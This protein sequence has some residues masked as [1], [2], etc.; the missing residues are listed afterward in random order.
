MSRLPSD[1]SGAR[2]RDGGVEEGPQDGWKRYQLPQPPE[3]SDRALPD[4]GQ[5]RIRRV[6][7]TVAL[8]YLERVANAIGRDTRA[9]DVVRYPELDSPERTAM[10]PLVLDEVK[11]F[12]EMAARAHAL[13]VDGT[14]YAFPS[15]RMSVHIERA[16]AGDLWDTTWLV[17]DG[18]QN[19]RR[20]QAVEVL[21]RS[22]EAVNQAGSNVIVLNRT[23]VMAFRTCSSKPFH[24][25]IKDLVSRGKCTLNE[26]IFRSLS[27]SGAA[28]YWKMPAAREPNEDEDDENDPFDTRFTLH[29]MQTVNFGQ[30][31][32]PLYRFF[33]NP[34]VSHGDAAKMEALGYVR[35]RVGA[36]NGFLSR[37]ISPVE[38]DSSL[39]HR[40]F[41]AYLS[42]Q[43]ERHEAEMQ[44]FAFFEN[45]S[46]VT[47]I[48]FAYN[49][50]W[51]AFS[52]AAL[53]REAIAWR[54]DDTEYLE[55]PELAGIVGGML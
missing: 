5:E 54:V 15:T 35:V 9:N 30:P 18:H 55:I 42:P 37:N 47:P 27:S 20:L 32:N 53:L 48:A 50:C 13:V 51:V 45:G 12:F 26:T 52:D 21:C 24:E 33:F 16:S 44:A 17:F 8:H 28:L 39:T 25:Q 11:R 49:D 14:R 3:V 34:I 36:I 7:R 40:T 31:K 19:A 29:Q 10:E 6:K 43:Y 41:L 38:Q 22:M 23:G 2:S 46:V 1:P 4:P